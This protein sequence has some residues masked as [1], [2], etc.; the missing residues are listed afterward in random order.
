MKQEQG[1]K[2]AVAGALSIPTIAVTDVLATHFGGPGLIVGLAVG[3]AA[4]L[5]TDEIR[6]ARKASVAGNP[7]PATTP[8][9]ST[10]NKSPEQPS[11][12]YR[13]FNGKSVR[14]PENKPVQ[15]KSD[16]QSCVKPDEKTQQLTVTQ[17]DEPMEALQ[18]RVS[19]IRDRLDFASDD[20]LARP[21][22][23][24]SGPFYFSDV[25]KTF[26]PSLEKI[27]LATM[28]D[29]RPMFIKARDLCH[30]ALT[31][32]TRGGKSQLVRQ[33]MSQ[34]CYAGAKVY[35]LNPHYIRYDLEAVDPFGR[36]CPEDWTPFEA[37]LKN[38]PRELISKTT[39]YKV[40]AHYLEAAR[41]KVDERLE[42][43]ARGGRLGSPH[44]IVIDEL[45]AIVDEVPSAPE[46]LKRILREGAKV[47]MFVINAS[48]DLQVGT[49]FKDVGGGIRSCYRTA[50]DVGSD[51]A[52]QRALG[53]PLLR[54]L[55]KGR[56]SLRCDDATSE[57]RVPF[58]D[59]EALYSL[60]G[61]STYV[62]STQYLDDEEEDDLVGSLM[63][64]ET[65]EDE[66]DRH[67]DSL[68]TQ[69]RR[70]MR[71]QRSAYDELQRRKAE[72]KVP[73]YAAASRERVTVPETPK[74][75][76]ETPRVE[77]QEERDDRLVLEAYQN[78]K[79]SGGAITVATGV[80]ANRVNFSL[81]RLSDAGLIDW[82]KRK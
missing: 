16:E 13:L 76:R 57:G 42:I 56:T 46:H 24:T 29:N 44:F 78:G 38:D 81:H 10:A 71:V 41:E 61:P 28:P 50:F 80:P 34:L 21:A 66:R 7:S 68:P 33:L 43:A 39:K 60:L 37:Y 82:Q 59:N 8:V 3:T 25:L 62:A 23:L 18:P 55:G 30:T 69:T 73:A 51:P 75:E 27:Y 35:L 74:M 53:L 17:A 65:E 58:V 14:E 12:A 64:S 5:V 20:E 1:Q 48:Q 63:H 4:Y 22:L 52:T 36:P 67:T 9:H 40:I 19:D 49:T 11:L 54:G 47:G 15:A 72:R 32:S 31:G 45:P 77:T 26:K 6:Q 70:P 2:L 79:R